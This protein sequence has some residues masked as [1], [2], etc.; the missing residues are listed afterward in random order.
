MAVQLEE[1]L[2]PDIQSDQNHST[3]QDSLLS[4]KEKLA[5]FSVNVGNIPI[6]ALLT[7]FLLLFY[8]DVVGLDPAAV[9]TL[10]LIARVFDG[11]NDP[12]MGYVVDHLPRTRMGRFRPYLLIGVVLCS[13]NYLVLWLGPSMANQGKLAIAFVSYILIGFT[14]DLMDIPLNSMIPVMSDRDRDRDTLSNIKGIGYMVG[15]A[16]ILIGAL[17]FIESFPTK[18]E[19]FHVVVVATAAFVLFFTVIGTFGIKERIFPIRAEKYQ[20]RNIVEILGARP[21]LILFLDTLLGQIGSGVSS[22]I[23]VFFFIY[24]LNRSDLYPL[25]TGTFAAGLVIAVLIAPRLI[26]AVGKKNAKIIASSISL[27]APLVLFFT[28]ADQP[29]IFILVGFL[30]SPGLGI[31]MVLS[32]GIQ[33]DNMDYVEWKLGYRAEGAVASMNSFIIKSAGGLGSAI[34]AYMLGVIHYVPNAVQSAQTIRGLYLLNYA[35][36]GLFSLAALLIWTFG[37]PL[38]R[39]ARRKMMGDLVQRRQDKT[40]EALGPV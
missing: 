22:G 23:G 8:V 5:F 33:A 15:G 38:T 4:L 30:T 40:N 11:I 9:G 20:L 10:F 2:D 39:P 21:V 12:L 35:I 19:G 34:G 3:E 32:Y 31:N 29:Y 26:R 37:Y 13:I 17:P 7:T 14:F 36:P 1:A 6:M 27:L 24:V 16:V 18:R 25:M 28:P